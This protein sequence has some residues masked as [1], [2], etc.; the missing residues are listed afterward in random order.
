MRRHLLDIAILF[1]SASLSCGFVL[2]TVP[3]I[4][5]ATLHVY[6][7]S[8]GGLLMLGIIAAAGDAV[9]RRPGSDFARALTESGHREQ[10]LPEI[11]KLERAVTLAVESSYDLHVRLL[12]QLREIARCRLERSGRTPGP[13]TLG[14][15]W[16]LLRDDRPEPAD[17]FAPGVTQAELRDLVADLERM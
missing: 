17:R 14:R 16:D 11:E 7:V 8:V 13:E 9:P 10:A 2:L 6:V 12:P 5:S 1:V 3:G 4:R 15:W